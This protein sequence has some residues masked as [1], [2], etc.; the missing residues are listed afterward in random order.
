M[1]WHL[2]NSN[3]KL[4]A[5]GKKKANDWGLH[6]M[7]GNVFEW[8]RDGYQKQ[9]PSGTNPYYK[10]SGVE[11]VR[12]GGCWYYDKSAC[13]SAFRAG[14]PPDSKTASLGFRLALVPVGI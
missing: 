3:A 14:Y 4:R 7:L 8:C 12:R 2:Q 6:D 9:L 5:V 1:A 13:R 10:S 11:R